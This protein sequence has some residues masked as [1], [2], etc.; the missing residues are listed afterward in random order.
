[1]IWIV[2]RGYRTSRYR[3]PAFILLY[4]NTTDS[5]LPASS[6]IHCPVLSPSLP[7][8]SLRPAALC[9]LPMVPQGGMGHTGNLGC[10][11]TLDHDLQPYSWI[12]ISSGADSFSLLP[13]AV[14]HR[15]QGFFSKQFHECCPVLSRRAVDCIPAP[16]KMVT[17]SEDPVLRYP[18]GSVQ[19]YD[20][21]Y[22]ISLCVGRAGN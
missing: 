8:L 2:L 9:P 21:V 11:H 10:C 15:K 3:L 19:F 18:V 5:I 6:G 4:D 17:H 12:H 13:Q 1:M 20:R 7:G 14:R 16:G 22:P